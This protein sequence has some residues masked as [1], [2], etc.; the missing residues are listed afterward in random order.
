[1][2]MGCISDLWYKAKVCLENRNTLS[3]DNVV[4]IINQNMNMCIITIFDLNR[5]AAFQTLQVF[6]TRGQNS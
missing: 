1:M 5:Y 2:F 3:Y 6:S 4:E